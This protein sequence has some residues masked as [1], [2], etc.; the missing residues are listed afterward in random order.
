MWPLP[1]MHWTS[2]YRRLWPQSP[3]HETRRPLP[4]PP[5]LVTSLGPHWRHFQN[6]SLDLTVQRPLGGV[7][8]GGHWRG[9]GQRKRVV[10]ILLERFLVFLSK[11]HYK[12]PNLKLTEAKLLWSHNSLLKWQKE[13]PK[14]PCFLFSWGRVW[15]HHLSLSSG[16]CRNGNRQ[17]WPPPIAVPVVAFFPATHLYRSGTVNSKSFVG[18][19][20]LRI[21][22]KFEL[23][24]AL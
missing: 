22:W 23:T 9:Y 13:F 24:Y 12:M 10:R 15:V 16:H 21:K 3:A 11:F 6:C 19:V 2:L 8:S 5:L 4:T 18:K 1:M 7:K 20:L 14:K 17:W